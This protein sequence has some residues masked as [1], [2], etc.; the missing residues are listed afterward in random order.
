MDKLMAIFVMAESMYQHVMSCQ[1]LA[2][3]AAVCWH[4]SLFLLYFHQCGHLVLEQLSSTS[5]S[6]CT[7][8]TWCFTEGRIALHKQD[9]DHRGWYRPYYQQRAAVSHIPTV[10]K[11]TSTHY[12]AFHCPVTC[13]SKTC[14]HPPDS[15]SANVVQSVVSWKAT[16][17]L[18]S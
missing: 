8:V 13:E 16:S 18:S 5:A 1:L 15:E 9:K 7:A 17:S 11:R 4:C 2:S 14:R 12:R 10:G 3:S 6:T